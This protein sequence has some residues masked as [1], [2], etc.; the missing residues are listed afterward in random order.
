MSDMKHDFMDQ[1]FFDRVFN[2]N[3]L[4]V[5]RFFL[6]EERYTTRLMFRNDYI[7]RSYYS[8]TILGDFR[9]ERSVLSKWDLV[10]FI[11]GKEYS[12][13]KFVDL[14]RDELAVIQLSTS[15]EC[16]P[17]GDWPGYYIHR[18]EYGSKVIFC[19][20]ENVIFPKSVY[21]IKRQSENKFE[22][23]M[24]SIESEFGIDFRYLQDFRQSLVFIFLNDKASILA[25][26]IYQNKELGTEGLLVRL[27]SNRAAFPRPNLKLC[28][29]LIGSDDKQLLVEQ[30]AIKDEFDLI[31][32]FEAPIP[33]EIYRCDV[34]LLDSDRLIDDHSGAPIRKVELKMKVLGK[35]DE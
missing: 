1:D 34:K 24:K 11:K 7:D 33:G 20:S 28:V 10:E 13:D 9:I 18:K 3:S 30:K 6:G 32:K 25:W 29:E 19:T 26:K 2:S 15:F 22:S 4:V 27:N 16:A 35:S 8:N 5:D 12:F 17:H 31:H 14:I 23:E 21:E